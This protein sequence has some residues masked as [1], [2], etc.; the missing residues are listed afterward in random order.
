MNR[1]GIHFYPEMK[2]IEHFLYLSLKI[3]IA[4]FAS[5]KSLKIIFY[6]NKFL[7]IFS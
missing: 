1:I 6:Q 3:C 4:S 5:L 7:C 2:R